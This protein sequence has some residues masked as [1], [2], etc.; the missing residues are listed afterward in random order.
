MSVLL[1]I[2]I[3]AFV[4]LSFDI[5]FPDNQ[6]ILLERLRGLRLYNTSEKERKMN[7]SLFARIYLMMEQFFLRYFGE[8]VAKG[9]NLAPLKTKLIQA[10]LEDMD[11]VQFRAKRFIFAILFAV[12]CLVMQNPNFLVMAALL[13]FFF[14]DYQLKGKITAR[15]DIIK[16][17]LPDFLDL[18]ASV[19]PGSKGFED[20][21]ERIC[22]RSSGILVDEFRKVLEQI[23]AG[24]RKRDALTS[25]AKRCGIMEIETLVAQII[26]S[27][28]LG[29]GLEDTLN[30]QADKMRS[31]K[32]Q[33][34][35]IKARKASVTLLFPSVFLLAAIM[36]VIAGPSIV[37]FLSAMSQ[38]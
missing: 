36:V 12:A 6:K 35:E 19:F 27:E 5:F 20:A 23:N 30:T 34:A 3:V 15:K 31:L 16:E 4:V 7:E 13:G 10:G 8:Q 2:A 28:M 22:D 32:R 25:M 21:V 29:T 37:T 18:L 38:M 26:Q 33:M 9:G 11:P 14:P 17:E 24:L 1:F